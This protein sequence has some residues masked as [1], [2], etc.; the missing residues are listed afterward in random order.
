MQGAHLSYEAKYTDQEDK[1]Y[2]YPVRGYDDRDPLS[3]Y[4][5]ST[6]GDAVQREVVEG[7]VKCVPKHRLNPT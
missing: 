7:N 6:D 5:D 3:D 1:K 4:D 2:V